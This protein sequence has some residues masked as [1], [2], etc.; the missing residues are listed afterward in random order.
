[1]HLDEKNTMRYCRHILLPAIQEDGQETLLQS[2]ALVVGAGGLGCAVLPYLAA[3]GVGRIS[4]FDAD[5]VDITNLQRQ[6]LHT[7]S[8]VGMNKVHSAIETLSALN[9]EIHLAAYEEHFTENHAELIKSADVVIDC[10]DNIETRLLLNRLCWQHQT[11]LISGSAIRMEGQLIHF[12]MRDNDPCYAC[13]AALFTEHSLS[14]MEA[15][16]LSPV[17]GTIG[18]LQA[19]E[20]LKALLQLQPE[21][22]S[23]L[24]YD[25]LQLEFRR[26]SVPK[27]A[28]CSVCSEPRNTKR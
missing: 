1:M 10:S 8:R 13:V 5:T 19:S 9:S 6:I 12:P 25:A 4:L 17:V 15:G 21:R 2:H 14:C 27:Q 7:E 3:A 22:V 20:A 23:L 16:V 18:T 24:L 26:F 11:P 28:S